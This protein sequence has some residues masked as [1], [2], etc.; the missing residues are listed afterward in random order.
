[1]EYGFGDVLFERTSFEKR[2]KA[3]EFVG[4]AAASHGIIAAVYLSLMGPRGMY[5]LGKTILQ[6]SQYAMRR[7]SSLPGV[8][9]PRFKAPHFKE[10]VVEFNSNKSVN[11][12]NKELLKEKIFGGIDLR[13]HFPEL[14]NSAL[15]CFT[16]VHMKEDIDR[17]VDALARVLGG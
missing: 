14:G 16:E 10:F 13:K 1:G 4:T 2:E 3:K 15:F 8:K 11:E 9:A 7:L 12:I 6:R 17:L 5:E